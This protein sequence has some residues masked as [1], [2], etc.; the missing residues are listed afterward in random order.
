MTTT[1]RWRKRARK[2]SDVVSAPRRG[3]LPW[4]HRRRPFV[5][6]ACAPPLRQVVPLQA[7]NR[8][9]ISEHLKEHGRCGLTMVD[10][11]RIDILT[12]R[13]SEDISRPERS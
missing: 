1:G 3:C 8:H 9:I 12:S 13:I 10:F 4:L 2:M 7:Y 11:W 6:S 5:A